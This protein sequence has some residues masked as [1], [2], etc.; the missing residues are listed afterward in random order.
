[1]LIIVSE[2]C[3]LFHHMTIGEYFS[4]FSFSTIINNVKMNNLLE[5]SLYMYKGFSVVWF[6][7]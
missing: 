1:M 2:W 7:K 6:K 5:V 4:S 3:I